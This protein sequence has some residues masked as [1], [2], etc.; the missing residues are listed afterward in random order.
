M[1]NHYPLP[2]LQGSTPGQQVQSLHRYLLQLV[3]Q[4]NRTAQSLPVQ[5]SAP[6][7]SVQ[8]QAE[9]S[10]AGIKGL[11]IQSAEI[12]E[13]YAQQIARRLEGQYVAQSDF[14]RYTQQMSAQITETAQALEAE[15][16]QIRS[17]QSKLPGIDD[18]LVQ[19][20]AHL[21]AGQLFTAGE[22]SSAM[23]EALAEPL[24]DGTP[25]YGL[26]IGQSVSGGFQKHARFTPYGMAFYDENGVE[27]A[28]ITDR[29][30]YIP[31]A[32]IVLSLEMGGFQ[33]QTDAL[34]GIVT[35]W[36]GG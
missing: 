23:L 15:F 6:Q 7:L 29:R 5:V 1:T 32:K 31:E 16:A 27:A 28:Y 20:H 34:G 12:V 4:L 13:S 3:R 36:I 22:E 2:S 17:L 35:R 9:A 10:F 8:Q 26:E 18:Y 33:M 14:G 21:Q 19:V 25:V 24:P 30:L 11:I